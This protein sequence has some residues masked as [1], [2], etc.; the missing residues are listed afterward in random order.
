MRKQK[1]I[2]LWIMG[3]LLVFLLLAGGF[4]LLL[5]HLIDMEPIKKR[6]LTKLSQEVGG[7]VKVERLDLSYFPRPRVMIH[8]V[9]LSVPGIVT[10]KLKS[11]EISPALL[12]LLK[13]KLRI[14]R[15]LI[16]SPDFTINIPEATKKTGRQRPRSTGRD[17]E[18]P[19]RFPLSSRQIFLI[20]P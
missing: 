12:A 17:R 19:L 16:A 15:I 9:S 7:Q 4:V 13:G 10:G 11:V 3:S 20:S 5:P 6:I 2:V 14:S 18:N 1:K 8:Q